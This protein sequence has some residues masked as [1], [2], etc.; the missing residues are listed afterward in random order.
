[1]HLPGEV[2][3][4][5]KVN[6]GEQVAE[7]AEELL[8]RVGP[9]LPGERV[10]VGADDG[11]VRVRGLFADQSLRPG[12]DQ[13][14]CRDDE[15][16]PPVDEPARRRECCSSTAPARAPRGDLRGWHNLAGRGARRYPRGARAAVP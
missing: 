3:P 16:R 2:R 12:P 10:A 1:E 8:G 11:V 5:V 13:D 7:L 14:P 6:D 4:D 9:R 15:D